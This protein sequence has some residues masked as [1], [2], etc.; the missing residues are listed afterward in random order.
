MT[1]FE[2]QP[3]GPSNAAVSAGS[4][5]NRTSKRGAI[6][7]G[8]LVTIIICVAPVSSP[9]RSVQPWSSPP[10]FS[11]CRRPHRHF[12]Q[13]LGGA[14]IRLITFRSGTSITSAASAFFQPLRCPQAQHLA[15]GRVPGFSNANRIQHV[16][17]DVRSAR[18]IRETFST[19]EYSDAPGL[20]FSSI[21]MQ[22]CGLT[23]NIHGPQ[24]I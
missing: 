2:R 16:P 1:S 14:L 3:A 11:L 5:A 6:S 15:G 19:A 13:R 23:R 22:M 20:F 12:Q 10:T 17:C 21:V 18:F 8:T 9:A 4:D 7:S 24:F